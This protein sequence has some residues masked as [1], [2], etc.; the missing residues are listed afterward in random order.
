MHPSTMP[1]LQEALRAPVWLQHLARQLTALPTPVTVQMI[2]LMSN[3][4][5]RLVELEEITGLPALAL[6]KTHTGTYF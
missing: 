1:V 4:V 3:A 2:S 6:S 5:R